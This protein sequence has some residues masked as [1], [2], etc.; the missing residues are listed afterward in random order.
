M[1]YYGGNDYRDYLAHHGVL[2]M[3]WGVRRYQ[4]YSTTGPRKGGK[5]GKEIGE[6]KKRTKVLRKVN[7]YVNKTRDYVNERHVKSLVKR[8]KIDRKTAETIVQK[9]N[10]DKSLNN[11]GSRTRIAKSVKKGY[12]VKAA[13]GRENTRQALL[14]IGGLS[15]SV[16]LAASAEYAIRN[17]NSAWGKTAAKIGRTAFKTMMYGPYM[18]KAGARSAKN[19]A[20]NVGKTVGKAAYNAY[21]KVNPKGVA[22]PDIMDVKWKDLGEA[23]MQLPAVLRKR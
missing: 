6:A 1:E 7:R 2:G 9:T 11:N 18:A 21:G 20:K 10:N 22:R 8:T 12:S 15:V 5:T 14:A 13:I 16:A 23:A 3:H 19:A 17:P 4:P